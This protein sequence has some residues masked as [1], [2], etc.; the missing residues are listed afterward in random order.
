MRKYFPCLGGNDPSP[1]D[2][3]DQKR[4]QQH[5]LS[6]SPISLSPTASL[7]TSPPP[8]Q[9]MSSVIMCGVTARPTP[10]CANHDDLASRLSEISLSLDVAK[11]ERQRNEHQIMSV[12]QQ[13]LSKMD[14]LKKEIRDMKYK[15]S[16]IARLESRNR[17]LRNENSRLLLQQRN[18]RVIRLLDRSTVSLP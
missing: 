18:S 3:P 7:Y 1:P 15:E 14:E 13:V 9:E 8:T 12:M 2:P 10:S 16:Y 5:L 17:Q 4:P 6:P 11:A